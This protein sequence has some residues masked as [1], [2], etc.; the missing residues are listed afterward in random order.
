MKSVAV[1]GAI[2]LALWGLMLWLSIGLPVGPGSELANGFGYD[3]PNNDT[4]TAAYF[5][6]FALIWVGFAFC[7]W[8]VWKAASSWRLA[9]VI[10]CFGIGFRIFM[11]FSQPVH[12]NDFYR[13]LWDG[14]SLVHGFNP[15]LYE[16]AALWMNELDVEEPLLEPETG[17][18]FQGRLWTEADDARLKE[19]RSLRDEN[20]EA[21][22]RIGHSQIPTIYP[23]AAQAMF[24]V[25]SFFFGD[26]V[27]GFRVVLMVFDLAAMLL[28]LCLLK[29]LGRNPAWILFYAWSPLIIV[30][31]A[32]S[33]HLDI[34]PI[35]FT[36]L[37][38]FC[39]GARK[40]ASA[41]AGL[42]VGV[43]GKYFSGFLLPIL[44]RPNW[45][46]ILIY[47]GCGAAILAAFVPFFFWQD[48]G[49]AQ[50]F[51][52]LTT[53][54]EDWQNN[55][56]AFLV[57][58]QICGFIVPASETSYLPA[59][60]VVA[61]I[62][63]GFIAW[64]AFTATPDH[65]T[66]VKKCFW[67]MT[68]FFVLNPTAFPWYFAWVVPFLCVFPRPSWLILMLTLQFYYLG[69]HDDYA[70]ST[71]IWLGFPVINWLTWGIFAIVWG[72]EQVIVFKRRT[73][74]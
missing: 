70:I 11:L 55:S 23:P 57:I 54:T 18:W 67:V 20:P 29:Q 65:E 25:S 44:F 73:V 9:W 71:A 68:V 26:S 31:F 58:D 13:Y 46:G 24:G 51:R 27:V 61:V 14:K 45:R 7:G 22:N 4:P 49:I 32:N 12:E 5:G 35:A 34:A 6:L 64:L 2:S 37:A 59:K 19:L 56:G 52:G 40:P 62:F 8:R 33:A 53:Y 41:A 28:I 69:F 1:I 50:V 42:V 15:Y 16:P 38:I 17:T 3:V 48:A 36:L 43:L 21:Y 60:I 72:I 66:L 47:G 10:V 63:L 39:V 74:A 30:E